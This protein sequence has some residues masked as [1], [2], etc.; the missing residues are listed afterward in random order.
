MEIILLPFVTCRNQ[1]EVVT[2]GGTR[3]MLGVLC[4]RHRTAL[5]LCG[6]TIILLLCVVL[7][8][9]LIF[10][11]L[12]RCFLMTFRHS[13]SGLYTARIFDEKLFLHIDDL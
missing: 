4:S 5:D 10:F 3:L 1:Y 13:K 9:Q 12:S 7:V 2:G 11:L 6:L 8:F